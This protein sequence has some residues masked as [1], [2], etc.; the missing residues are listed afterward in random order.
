M[1]GG[2]IDLIHG[3]NKGVIFCARI[4]AM[5]STKGQIRT[6]TWRQIATTATA[7]RNPV[8]G[9]RNQ[10]RRV[11]DKE[12]DDPETKGAEVLGHELV[13]FEVIFNRMGMRD[14]YTKGLLV[15]PSGTSR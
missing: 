9:G 12:D 4:G 2:Y 13:W 14:I 5:E 1:F 8:G 10:R 6:L 15:A 11:T 3:K 7:V